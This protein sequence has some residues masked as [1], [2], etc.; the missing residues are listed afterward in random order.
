MAL[1]RGVTSVQ[2]YPHRKRATGDKV[3]PHDIV[4][5]TFQMKCTGFRFENHTAFALNRHA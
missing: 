2:P 4:T 1:V 3:T 5:L